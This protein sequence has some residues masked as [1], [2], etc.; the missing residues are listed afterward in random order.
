M[1]RRL[2]DGVA[3]AHRVGLAVGG[4]T[5]DNV[6]LRPN[7]LVGL[8]AVPAATGTVEGD[9]AALGALLE[10]GLTGLAAGRLA[11]AAV[12]GPPDLVA[13][14]RRT[15]STEPGQGLSSVA[16]MAALLAE[17]PRTGPNAV[18]SGRGD[19]DGRRRRLRDRRSDAARREPPAGG[20][21]R[22][23]ARTLPPVP[24]VRP[25][26]TDDP[27]IPPAAI[28]GDTIDAG[29]VAPR[30]APT[31]AGTPGRQPDPQRGARPG[32][33][34]RRGRRIFGV[35]RS[36]VDQTYVGGGYDTSS[37]TARMPTRR[38]AGIA[39]SSS[40]SGCWRWPWSR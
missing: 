32:R 17:R 36:G 15:Q 13:L 18:Q 23:A 34:R 11:G 30:S 19:D 24:A 4:L 5:P 16:A 33:R 20:R 12:T 21:R 37:P 25:I 38:S 40:G 7:G 27:P 10:V 35:L 39:P 31:Q 6:V 1:L 8:R 3:E 26:T 22:A 14:V 28:G 29:S 2:A 9:I